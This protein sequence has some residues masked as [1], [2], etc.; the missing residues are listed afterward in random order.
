MTFNALHELTKE[1]LSDIG[2]T[3]LGDIKNVLR[4]AKA[5]KN[6][7]T[8]SSRQFKHFHESTSCKTASAQ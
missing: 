4:K 1:D 6:Q 3:V 5:N 7:F 8:K 2:I